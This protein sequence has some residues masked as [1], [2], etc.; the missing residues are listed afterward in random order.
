MLAKAA[1]SPDVLSGGRLHSVASARRSRTSAADQAAR[2]GAGDRAATRREHGSTLSAARP[3]VPWQQ[4]TTPRSPDRESYRKCGSRLRRSRLRGLALPT[5]VIRTSA[6]SLRGSA[7]TSRATWSVKMGCRGWVGIELATHSC[8]LY[9]D[10]FRSAETPPLVK[11]GRKARLA[12]RHVA[13][14]SDDVQAPCACELTLMLRP[15]EARVSRALRPHAWTSSN[16]AVR[17]ALS[18]LPFSE[19]KQGSGSRLWRH[20]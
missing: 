6:R 5:Q 13:C 1:A 20:P 4:P 12:L 7:L 11:A 16:P 2:T 9:A 8:A 18:R 17:S 15:G 19:G 10:G 14:A 3:A